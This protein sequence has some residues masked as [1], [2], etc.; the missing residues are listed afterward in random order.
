MLGSGL[1][2]V[3][4][5][6]QGWQIAMFALVGICF[7]LTLPCLLTADP[8]QGGGSGSG[9]RPRPSLAAA[10]RRPEIRWGLVVV[11]L[12]QLGLR[13]SMGMTGPFMIDNGITPAELGFLTGTFATALCLVAI[14]GIGFVIRKL[15]AST[16]LFGVLAL[17]V[18][19][20]AGF[21]AAAFLPPTTLV[22]SGLYLAKSVIVAISFVALYTVAM[23]WATPG[24]AGV[25][26]SIFQCA[27]SAISVVAGLGAGVVAQHLGYQACFGLAT[28]ATLA[29][30]AALPFIL[31]RINRGLAHDQ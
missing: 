20:Y 9:S 21:A 1:F 10:F 13:F 29:G 4:A 28:A 19:V 3:V 31:S 7:L 2:L 12:S 30:L 22:L 11:L 24:Q 5:G 18:L 23:A 27:D 26:F 25:D 6:T 8:Q 17:Q 15:G 16:V 14:G